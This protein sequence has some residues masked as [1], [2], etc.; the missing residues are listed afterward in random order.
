MAHR[1]SPTNIGVS[2]LSNL[3]AFD[4]G[5]VSM[6][7]LVERTRQSFATLALLER[8]HGHFLNWY[9]TRTLQPL[10]P[11]YVSSVDSGNLAGYLLTLRAGLRELPTRP[12]VAPQLWASLSVMGQIVADAVERAEQAKI[13]DDIGSSVWQ[14]LRESFSQFGAPNTH[15]MTVSAAQD[16][17]QNLCLPL[18]ELVLD[19][20]THDEPE[21]AVWLRE[22]QE[23]CSDHLADLRSMAPWVVHRL[24]VDSLLGASSL[25]DQNKHD[26]QMLLADLDK[27]GTLQDI[28]DAER[29]LAVIDTLLLDCSKQNASGE[30]TVQ[31]WLVALREMLSSAAELARQRIVVI[32]ALV[33]Q[34]GELAAIEYDFLYDRSRR[35]LAIGY[36]VSERRRDASFYDLLASEARLGSFVAIAQGQLEQEHWFAL[37]RL[38]TTSNGQP[39][40]LSWSGSMFEYLMPLLVMPTYSDTLLDQT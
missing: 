24:L 30:E 23:Q 29:H 20:P 38:L 40:L 25:S 10:L 13:S 15:V 18:K 26:V 16:L 31:S 27:V 6:G 28:A 36:N 9:D 1:T 3:A 39:A 2:L 33:L 8:Y 35:L 37:G 34:C 21:L 19:P 17:L 22:L 32:E 4:F 5:Y 11:R 12:L 14:R 7:R